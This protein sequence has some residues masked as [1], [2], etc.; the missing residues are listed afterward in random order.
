MYLTVDTELT[1]LGVFFLNYTLAI[2]T[3]P[4]L[5]INSHVGNI[6]EKVDS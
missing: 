1:F 5:A 6:I 3:A 4:S 2:N